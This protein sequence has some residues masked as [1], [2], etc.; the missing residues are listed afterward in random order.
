MLFLFFLSPN[1]VARVVLDCSPTP[2]PLALFSQSTNTEMNLSRSSSP[3]A[4]SSVVLSER[5]A[6]RP[7]I[8]CQKGPKITILPYSLPSIHQHCRPFLCPPFSLLLFVSSSPP[9]LTKH[10]DTSKSKSES[11]SESKWK[12]KWQ[13]KLKRKPKWKPRSK[14]KHTHHIDIDSHP[15]NPEGRTSH[16]AKHT[17]TPAPQATSLSS[18]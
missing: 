11:K 6:C 13:S 8:P 5:G 7:T 9:M 17:H 12:S 1:S 3:L 16:P 14:Y 10:S 2:T 15:T 18:C 4:V